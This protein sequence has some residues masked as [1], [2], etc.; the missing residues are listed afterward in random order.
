MGQEKIVLCDTDIIIEFYRN[1]TEIVK[2][3]RILVKMILL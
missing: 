1:N 2:E 3:Q